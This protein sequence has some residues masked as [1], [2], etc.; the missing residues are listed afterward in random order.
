MPL[1]SLDNSNSF[2]YRSGGTINNESLG[3]LV[4]RSFRRSFNPNF[5]ITRGYRRIERKDGV[6]RGT[7]GF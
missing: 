6:L 3:M 1:H 2:R 4:T 5:T 7:K